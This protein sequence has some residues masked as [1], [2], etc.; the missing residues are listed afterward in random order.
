MKLLKQ[1]LEPLIVSK[2]YTALSQPKNMC[3]KLSSSNPQV[4]RTGVSSVQ[5]PNIQNWQCSFFNWPSNYNRILLSNS[6][7]Q[8]NFR[9]QINSNLW[10]S[11]KWSRFLSVFISHFMLLWF[12][13]W[14]EII[15]ANVK[16]KTKYWFVK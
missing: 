3:F 1:Y 2:Y 16:R 9:K 14:H 15:Q 13:C 5:I 4:V 6:I 7:M 11:L 8:S 12:L 10:F